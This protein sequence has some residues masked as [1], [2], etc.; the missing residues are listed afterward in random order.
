MTSGVVSIDLSMDHQPLLSAIVLWFAAAAWLLLAAVLDAPLV[1]QRGRFQREAGSPVTL[2]GV[3]ATAVLGTRFAM[4]DFSV[5]AAVLLAVAG[6]GWALLLA[7][8]LLHWQTPTTGISFVAGVATD[9]V[10]LLS[11]TLAVTFRAGWLL[12]AAVVLLLLG[13]AFYVFTLARFDL[14]QLFLGQGDHWIAG[15]ALAISALCAGVITKSAGVLGLFSH[16]HQ[17]LTV[18]TLVLWCLA[19]VWLPI[20]IVS[21]A[22]RPRLRYDVRRWATVFPLGMYAA[23]SFTVGRVTGDAGITRF[24][25]VWTWVAVAATLLALAGLIRH[26]WSA[27]PPGSGGGGEARHHRPHWYHVA[28]PRR[29]APATEPAPIAPASE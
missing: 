8:V 3:A 9:G 10:A 25:E 22:V 2:A 11:A 18:G 6:A 15:G 20:L 26:I 28:Q 21:E 5:A 7:P 16:Q 29:S 19:L 13:L 24:G 1:Y 17:I 23:C 12:S 14:R 4:Q 27:A